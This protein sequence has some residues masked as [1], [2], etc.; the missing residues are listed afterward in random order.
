M[1]G[2]AGRCG[3]AARCDGLR[4]AR[5]AA[6][7][8]RRPAPTRTRRSSSTPSSP[9]PASGAPVLVPLTS[10]LHV[11]GALT[12]PGRVLLDIGTGYYVEARGDAGRMWVCG[13]AARRWGPAARCGGAAAAR[14]LHTL[15]CRPAHP[16]LSF[17]LRP[18]PSGGRSTAAAK[19]SSCGRGSTR[20]G[21][22]EKETRGLGVERV[23]G[24][25]GAVPRPH[26][27]PTPSL[28]VLKSRQ[29]ALQQIGA[30]T[31]GGGGGGSGGGGGGVT[32]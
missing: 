4:A 29:Q 26:R 20:S 14:P 10:S 21:R 16:F 5:R 23:G 17:S 30:L 11:R 9:F 31:A 27:P 19:S 2:V 32:A 24:A 15:R 13:T 3:R 8:R 18:R 28:Q 7:G 25:R 22:R 1:P 6:A 12:T